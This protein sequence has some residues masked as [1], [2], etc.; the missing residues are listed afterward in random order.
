MNFRNS[1]CVKIIFRYVSKIFYVFFIVGFDL[2]VSIINSARRPVLF[3]GLVIVGF[4]PRMHLFKSNHD[5]EK[6][7]YTESEGEL[8]RWQRVVTDSNLKGIR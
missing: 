4:R 7:I 1:E 5:H 8:L 2:A 3:L 6:V